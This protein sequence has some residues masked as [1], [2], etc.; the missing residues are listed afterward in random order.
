MTSAT[1]V[2]NVIIDVGGKVEVDDM[3]DVG[4]IETASGDSGGNHD[5]FVKP[6]RAVPICCGDTDEDD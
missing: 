4:D 3:G 1:N 2:V 5:V 6:I